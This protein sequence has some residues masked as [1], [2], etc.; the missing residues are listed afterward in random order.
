MVSRRSLDDGD[1]PRHVKGRSV[2]KKAG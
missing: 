2:R 1:K